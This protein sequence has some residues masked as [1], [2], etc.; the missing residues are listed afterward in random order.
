VALFGTR[1]KRAPGNGHPLARAQ[2]LE[3][4]IGI[5]GFLT[6]MAVVQAI[7]LELR[8]ESAGLAATVLLGFVV[9][10]GWALRARRR[11]TL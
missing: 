4:L 6:V 1:G 3:V 10:L 11:I 8:G 9:A 2:R 5:L 7:A